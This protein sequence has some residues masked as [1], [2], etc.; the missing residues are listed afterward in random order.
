MK[1]NVANRAFFRLSAIILVFMIFLG[2]SPVYAAA[3]YSLDKAMP[4]GGFVSI[5]GYD[6]YS[7][8]Y[9]AFL[10]SDE[11]DCVIRDFAGKI[12]AM[13]SG[14]AIA[15]GTYTLTFNNAY[16]GSISGYI[17][18]DSVCVY[19]STDSSKKVTVSI[20]GLRA[21]ASAENF[22]LIPSA[23]MYPKATGSL[24]GDYQLDYYA[25]V[26]GKLVHYISVYSSSGYTNFYGLTLDK[27]PDFM[28]GST[29]YYSLNGYDYYE[30]IQ[31]AI[32]EK[33]IIGTY[34]PYYKYLSFRTKTAYTPSELNSYIA[35]KNSS[36][37][38][39]YTCVYLGLGASFIDSQNTYGANAMLE[40]A[41]ANVESGY[42]KS[43]IARYK[44]NIFSVNA[45]DS[46]AA[47]SADT[48][49]TATDAIRQHAKYTLS[50][51]YF[52]AY[53]YV[54]S[55]L[56]ASY[57]NVSDRA[58]GWVNNYSGDSRYFGTCLGNKALGIN[59]KY[60]SD[61]WHGEKIAA[62]AYQLDE[63][64]GGKDYG[65]YTLGVTN[66]M[67]Y[68]FSQPSA[69]SFKLYKY[70]TRDPKRSA[71]NLSYGPS[72]FNILILGETGDYYKIQSDIPVNAEGR[73]CNSWD[74]N[75]ETSIA[76]VLKSDVDIIRLSPNTPLTPPSEP[77][78]PSTEEP[79]DPPENPL[80]P[81][82][83]PEEPPLDPEEPTEPTEPVTPP[84]SGDDPQEEVPA[85]PSG[86]YAPYKI[87][88]DN[89]RITN[90]ADGTDIEEFTAKFTDYS[91]SVK[92]G[93][94][95]ITKGYVA[96]AMTVILQKEGEEAMSFTAV[97]KGD[98]NADGRVTSTDVVLTMRYIVELDKPGAE[99]ALACDVNGDGKYTSTDVVL[100]RRYIVGLEESL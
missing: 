31:D 10:S 99:S 62:M 90:I 80:D 72:G 74:Y 20:S 97:V 88:S 79:E 86:D 32:G 69:A 37:N 2:V 84:E 3:S 17:T 38:T 1:K 39:G 68:A 4:N 47:S 65:A 6:S 13:K 76:Y 73:G 15:K 96:T 24:A 63:Y 34:Y 91:V 61:P 25:N 64:L 30:S 45:V 49:S 95:L 9:D 53:F 11:P 94:T 5:G 77:D 35:Y 23:Q 81:E 8:A 26:G 59:V 52:D 18:K 42:G 58:S 93:E 27:A 50:R 60:A 98:A 55:S 36:V 51:G 75:Y 28:L 89:G 87:D 83:P 100:M 46:S 67:T 85:I 16:E 78:P 7:R 41:F 19:L 66:K 82:V 71:G 14:L 44:N 33:K 92:S 40:I 12:I 48:Y 22:T 70:T 43:Y 54:D 29:R 21:S 57:Y 56:A